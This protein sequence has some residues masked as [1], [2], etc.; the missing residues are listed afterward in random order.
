MIRYT[1]VWANAAE[2]ELAELWNNS[3]DRNELTVAADHIDNNLAVDAHLKGVDAGDGLKVISF[4]VLTAYFT[5]EP[6]DRM[7]KVWAVYQTG[8]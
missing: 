8:T 5:A 7:V 3:K 6:D 2:N 1:V 4:S